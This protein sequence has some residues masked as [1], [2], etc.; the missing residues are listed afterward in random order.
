MTFGRGDLREVVY[1]FV[2]VAFT[3]LV[4]MARTSGFGSSFAHHH[5]G[6]SVESGWWGCD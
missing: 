5:F 4:T 6:Y 1:G 2:V 3:Y